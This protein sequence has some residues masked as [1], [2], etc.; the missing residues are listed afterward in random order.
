MYTWNH[1]ITGYLGLEGAH[2][3]HRITDSKTLGPCR[4]FK[5]K[6]YDLISQS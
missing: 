1:K 5:T 3:D 2:K 6:S 4:T